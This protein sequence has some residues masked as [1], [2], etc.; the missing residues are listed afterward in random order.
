MSAST[1][2]SAAGEVK[3]LQTVFSQPTVEASLIGVSILLLLL[4]MMLMTNDFVLPT[5]YFVLPTSYFLLP[6]SYFLLPTSAYCSP[7][8]GKYALSQLKADPA[9]IR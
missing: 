2:G 4:L 3:L 7:P 8:H 5:S 1:S 6:T 9:S